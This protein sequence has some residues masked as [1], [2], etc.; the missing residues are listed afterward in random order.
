MDTSPAQKPKLSPPV[1]KR[2]GYGGSVNPV[3]S[4][5]SHAVK[6]RARD[7]MVLPHET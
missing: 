4:T 1:S 2:P 3:M 7:E 6:Y 5:M